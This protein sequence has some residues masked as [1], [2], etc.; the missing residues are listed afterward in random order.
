M[1][2]IYENFT[3]PPDQSFTIRSEI[4]EIK[5]YTT[6]KSHINFEIALI[7][8]CAGKRFIGDHIE[9]FEGTELVLLGS[10]LP[11]CWQ[12]YTVLDTMIPPQATVIH[13]FPTFLGQQLLDKPEA[14]QLNELFERAAKGVSFSGATVR[15]AKMIMQQ[16]LFTSGMTRVVLM[17]NLLDTLAQSEEG[18]VLSS[19]YYN[20]VDSS[21]EAQK[22]NK[23]FDYIFKN[24]QEEISLKTVADILPLSPAAFCRYFKARTNRTLIDF[25]KEVRIGHAAKLLLE[26]KHNVTE[27]CYQSGYN[28]LSNFN[29]HFKEVK[30]LSPRDFVKQYST[31]E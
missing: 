4:L 29:K 1:Q 25:V 22:I 23:V 18:K 11:H 8:N 14:H 17:L 27:A 7:E 24:F 16:M 31:A 13:F 28:N 9:D 5:K 26:K 30:G 6:L 10:Y 15:T 2:Y 21:M 12:Y 19:P 3:F 20:A